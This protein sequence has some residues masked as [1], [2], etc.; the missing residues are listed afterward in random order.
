MGIQAAQ[1]MSYQNSALSK[2]QKSG[3]PHCNFGEEFVQQW[4]ELLPFRSAKDERGSKVDGGKMVLLDSSDGQ[5]LS[6]CPQ[7]TFAYE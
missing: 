3:F 7:T 6:L 5:D 2:R 1:D 4:I